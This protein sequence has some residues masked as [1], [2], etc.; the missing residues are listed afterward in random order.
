METLNASIKGMFKF[1]KGKLE[2]NLL[3]KIE[4]QGPDLLSH[5]KQLKEWEKKYENNS[6]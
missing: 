3:V 1:S 2:F 5:Q 4:W 6:A